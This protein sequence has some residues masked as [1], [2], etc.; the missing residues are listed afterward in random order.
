[1]FC[2]SCDKCQCAGNLT[3][4]NE[5]PQNPIHICEIFYVWG[6]DYM[7]PFISSFVNSVPIKFM[8]PVEYNTISIFATGI[9]FET[10][11]II[12]EIC[13]VGFRNLRNNHQ[14][15]K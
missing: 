3:R 1:M 6:I 5:M 10:I 4:R 14:N 8:P 11:L 9:R 7:G 13:N 2:K 12:R 15:Q